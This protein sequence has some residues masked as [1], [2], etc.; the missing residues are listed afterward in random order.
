MVLRRQWMRL[1]GNRFVATDFTPVDAGIWRGR[2]GIEYS[3]KVG[4]LVL[5][6]ESRMFVIRHEIPRSS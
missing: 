5:G 2:A 1:G 6:E 4:V 3:V